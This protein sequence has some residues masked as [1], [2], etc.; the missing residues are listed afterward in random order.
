MKLIVVAVT[1]AFAGCATTQTMTL[2]FPFDYKQAASLMEPGPNTIE[3]SALMRQNS[4]G[5]VTCAGLPVYLIPATDYA[6]RR[7]NVIYGS[8]KFAGFGQFRKFK[9]EIPAYERLIRKGT[10]NAQGFF[11]FDKVADGS[12]FI[13]STISWKAGQYNVQGGGLIERVTVR[14]GQTVELTLAP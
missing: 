10:C 4:G 12:F 1:A 2:D 14:G 13:Q 8:G 9:P 3:G 5:V 6:E 7:V 11:H